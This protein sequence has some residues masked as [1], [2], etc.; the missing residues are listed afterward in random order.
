MMALLQDK[1]EDRTRILEKARELF[2]FFGIRSITMD[3]ISKHLGMSKKT[4]YNH[5]KDKAEIVNIIIDDLIVSHGNKLNETRMISQN[6]I[7]ELYLQ[8]DVLLYFF[9]EISP[10]IFF[11]MDK[12]FP[13]LSGHFTHH[14]HHCILLGIKENLE[15]GI[16]EGL[17]R[18]D[19]EVEFISNARLN[20]FV[21]A[22]DE[23]AFPEIDFDVTKTLNKL[24]DFYLHAVCSDKGKLYIKS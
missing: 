1:T 3:D 8:V 11:E 15:R 23:N 14:R 4:L 21:A 9:K 16:E 19:L 20:Q 5:F 18:P 10:N 17:Y 2:F 22:F 24:N 12:Y 13:E 6:A 7:D